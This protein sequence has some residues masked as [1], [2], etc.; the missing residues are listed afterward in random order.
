MG[1]SKFQNFKL[2]KIYYRQSFE[3]HAGIK[4]QGN[5]WKK[6]WLSD[7]MLRMSIAFETHPEIV[8]RAIYGE[9]HFNLLEIFDKYSA[10]LTSWLCCMYTG[11]EI[12]DTVKLSIISDNLLVLILIW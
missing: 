3:C 12:Y 5:S 1:V 10:M 2:N 9:I 7:P 6:N 8:T 11:K 4:Q